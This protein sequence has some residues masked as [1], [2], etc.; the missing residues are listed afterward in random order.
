MCLFVSLTDNIVP[1]NPCG[2]S[3][4]AGEA[5]IA[6]YTCRLNCLYLFFGKK[7]VKIVKIVNYMYVYVRHCVVLC[8]VVLCCV[9]VCGLWFVVCGLWFVV[10]GLWFVVCG[11]WFVV[12][13]LL[14][15]LLLL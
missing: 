15:L 8:C 11:L 12:C 7:I 5:Q 2:N 3:A 1:S 13:C 6:P 14:L 9:V 4:T 10:C